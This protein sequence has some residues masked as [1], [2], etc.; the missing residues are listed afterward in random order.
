MKR[1][2]GDQIGRQNA[3]GRVLDSRVPE[4]AVLAG[5]KIAYA[6]MR[7]PRLASGRPADQS[8][9]LVIT[10]AALDPARTA[11]TAVAHRGQP[12]LSG[13]ASMSRVK[14]F[15]RPSSPGLEPL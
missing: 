14:A 10:S 2:I 9:V 1:E 13:T 4:R 6:R 3:L 11:K 7:P 12:Q 15:F 8:R 5:R